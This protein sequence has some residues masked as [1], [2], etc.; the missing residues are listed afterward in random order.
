MWAGDIS[1]SSATCSFPKRGG[2][3]GIWK[4]VSALL[5]TERQ[6]FGCSA[7]SVDADAKVVSFSDGR[8][9]RYQA[10][11]STIPLDTTLGWLGKTDWAEDLHHS[12]SHIIG[13]GIRGECPHG[14]KCW[15]Y[16]PES[17][18]P[19]YRCAGQRLPARCRDLG[20]RLARACWRGV[21][22][23]HCKSEHLGPSRMAA[24]SNHDAALG[25]MTRGRS[26]QPAPSSSAGPPSS[27][28]MH[29]RTALWAGRACPPSAAAPA[30]RRRTQRPRVDRGGR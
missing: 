17:D 21:V 10:L 27:R 23:A 13:V 18:C 30:A 25:T 14:A 6:R 19:F 16:F 5:P 12:A 8:Q 1:S 7:V 22:V 4:A 3:G 11:V 9:I 15:L 24:G 28:T 26:T 29:A 20:M 2:T